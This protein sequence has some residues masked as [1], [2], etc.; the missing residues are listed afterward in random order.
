MTEE[1]PAEESRARR[2]MAMGQMAASLAHEIRNPLG[3]MELFCSL[4]KKDLETV[5]QSLYLAE[6]IHTGIRRLEHIIA[7]CLQF[8]KEIVPRKKTVTD[9]R[10]FISD[11]IAAVASKQEGAQCSVTIDIRDQV[12]PVVD[13]HLMQQVLINLLVNAIDAVGERAA[14]KEAN[15]EPA[16]VVTSNTSDE[17]SWQLSVSDNGVGISEE[18]SKRV[19]DPFFSTKARG[20]GLGLAIV[21]SI[22][23]A[24]HGTVGI[25]SK[26]L[27]GTTVTVTIPTNDEEGA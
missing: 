5:P 6:Q 23:L 25:T 15:F 19:F 24:H 1:L 7:N 11:A 10:Q 14:R 2:L 26:N 12:S 17:G 27:Q 4:L 8:A 21:H 3:S 22:V 9:V 16:V 20:T 13:S 18:D